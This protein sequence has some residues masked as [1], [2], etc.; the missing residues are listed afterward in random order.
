M[1]SIRIRNG[2]G[3]AILAVAALAGLDLNLA[4]AADAVKLNWL[5]GKPP[6][7]AQSV[8]WG[9]PW[10]KG[11]VQKTD[12]LTLK[13]ADG[14]NVPLQTW[15]LAYW[16][17]GSIMWSGHSISA[18]PGLAG[19][20]QITVGATA[21]PA[22]KI[23]C[24][25][26]AAGITIDTG[27]TQTR[28]L[29]TGSNLFES[30]SIG[31]RRIA[32]NGRLVLQL[33]DRSELATRKVLREEDFESRI[34]TV[35]LEQQGPIRAVVKIEGDHKSTTGSGRGCRSRC[36]CTSMRGWI[37]CASCIRSSSMAT[38]RRISS[39]GWG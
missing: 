18:T 39:R 34:K 37:R 20:F 10:P 4:S 19:P 27:V 14:T 5:D 13:A 38:I 16:P 28:I 36:G 21:A 35:T 29:K 8:A 2:I 32:E 11:S 30:I 33:E 15:P 22:A 7:A 25:Q 31:G 3:I 12:A 23:T 17:D 1:N 26:D 24:T 9:V 6:A